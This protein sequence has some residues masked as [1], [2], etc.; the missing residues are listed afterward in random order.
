MT[1]RTYNVGGVL[2]AVCFGL[3]SGCNR[4]P[5]QRSNAGIEAGG[6]PRWGITSES[7][8][9]FTIDKDVRLDVYPAP[10]S[11]S[12]QSPTVQLS[13]KAPPYGAAEGR[14]A[15]C[16]QVKD[17]PGGMALSLLAPQD[18]SNF[19]GGRLVFDLAAD[20]VDRLVVGMGWGT[21]DQKQEQE[22]PLAGRVAGVTNTKWTSVA[23]PLA[24]FGANLAVLTRPF[25]ITAQIGLGETRAFCVDDVHFEAP[26][27]ATDGSAPATKDAGIDSATADLANANSDGRPCLGTWVPA[28][29]VPPG[30]SLDSLVNGILLECKQD[31]HIDAPGEAKIGWWGSSDTAGAILLPTATKPTSPAEGTDMLC[32]TVN[33]GSGSAFVYYG[34]PR[35]YS[36]FQGGYLETELYGDG[37]VLIGLSW[38]SPGATSESRNSVR[39]AEHV[40]ATA[41]NGWRSIRIPL[42]LFGADLSSL[43]AVASFTVEARTSP[44]T[45][46]ADAIRFRKATSSCSD[47]GVAPD[48]GLDFPDASDASRPDS[49]EVKDTPGAGTDSGWLSG[50]VPPA[51]VPAGATADQLVYGIL[52][53]CKQDVRIDEADG[54]KV[55][56]WVGSSSSGSLLS[57]GDAKPTTPIEGADMLCAT[58][59]QGSGSAFV[60]YAAPR[61]FTDYE[62]GYLELEL[63]GDA[64]V[65]VGVSWKSPG[66]TVESRKTVRAADYAAPATTSGWKSIRIPLCTFAADLTSLVAL[67][68]F[69]VEGRTSPT[70]FCVDAVRYRKPTSFCRDTCA[71]DAGAGSSDGKDG[72]IASDTDVTANADADAVASRDTA[73]SP[74]AQPDA[75][76]LATAVAAACIPAGETADQLVYGILLEC[77]QDVRIDEIGEAKVGWWGSSSSAGG[78]L[79]P[80]DAKPTSPVE[81]T[82]MLCATV[83][84]GSGS[85]FLYYDTPRSY[86]DYQNGFLELELFADADVLIGLSWRSPGAAAEARKTVRAADHVVASAASGWKSI[87]IPLCLFGADLTSVVAVAS[88]SVEGRSSPT[89]FCVDAVRYR[90]ATPACNDSCSIA[91]PEIGDAASPDMAETAIPASTDSNVPPLAGLDGGSVLASLLPNEC[92]PTGATAGQLVYGILLECKQDVIIDQPGE[93]HVGWWASSPEVGGILTPDAAKPTPPFEG[94]S[95]VCA[96]VSAGTGS[97]FVYYDNPRDFSAFQNGYLEA[98]LFTFTPDV[99]VG[100]SWMDAGGYV[101]NIEHQIDV[102]AIDYAV[103]ASSSGEWMSLRIPLCVFGADL[104]YLKAVAS[105][106]LT[107]YYSPETFCVDAVRFRKSTSACPGCCTTSC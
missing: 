90:K 49:A 35:D 81:G 25:A 42:Y 27:G 101:G 32:A 104:G 50:A 64:D 44:T 9:G 92:I 67:A 33:T 47:N 106:S 29:C 66:S 16:L 80:T 31:V 7:G 60:Y 56:W 93:A 63:F 8:V 37:D 10:A 21:A 73:D 4:G 24:D 38:K 75:G 17:K 65:L 87:R 51:C 91:A 86:L 94:S 76:Y 23:I 79:S 88:F 57:S 3:G 45:F 82:D 41:N 68:T 77:K 20:D 18:M 28:A 96:T 61:S 83:N 59:T 70:T 43:V 100:I 102:R 62:N 13:S 36:A 39:A 99:H 107:N 74:I 15:H 2:L 26:C 6:C 89:T 69:S 85:A 53:E 105:F 52:L 55:G 103:S 97:F 98:E 72:Q 1:S 54:A 71:P 84:Q 5:T 30:V 34:T 95:M 78:I 14:I 11:D 12:S 19:A 58:V 48:G 40:V 46:C 22:L